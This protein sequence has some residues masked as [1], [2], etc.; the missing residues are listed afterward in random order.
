MIVILSF[1]ST[2][3]GF[4]V[5]LTVILISFSVDLSPSVNVT[6]SVWSPTFFASYPETL[7]TL[8]F[9]SDSFAS[10]SLSL[11]S[12]SPYSTVNLSV[13]FTCRSLLQAVNTSAASA[14]ILKSF[15]MFFSSLSITYPYGYDLIVCINYRCAS[16]NNCH[17]C[18]QNRVVYCNNKCNDYYAYQ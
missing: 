13:V 1:F 17:D 2:I 3:F 8:T 15:F 12:L 6:F 18:S 7:S 11:S 10:Y 9:S 14:A 16:R 5:S 4:L